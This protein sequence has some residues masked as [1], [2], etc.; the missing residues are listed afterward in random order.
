MTGAGQMI[1]HFGKYNVLRPLRAPLL[2]LMVMAACVSESGCSDFNVKHVRLGEAAGLATR[3]DIRVI[4]ERADPYPFAVQKHPTV[5][6]AE[7][8]PD[9]ALALN[10]AL[11]VE[12]H[13]KT[14]GVDAGAKGGY[15]T[16][17]AALALAGRTSAVVALRDG[18]FRACEGYANG[19]IGRDSYALILSHYGDLLVTLILGDSAGSNVGI[20]SSV[21][22]EKIDAPT[23]KS[24]AADA[25]TPAAKVGKTAQ[26]TPPAATSAAPAADSPKAAATA[27]V[28][29]SG[30]SA[31]PRGFTWLA[32]APAAA[33]KSVKPKPTPKSTTTAAKTAGFA[34]KDKDKTPSDAPPVF[35]T[36]STSAAEGIANAYFAGEGDRLVK[37]M[38][39][40]CTAEAERRHAA[41]VQ[42]P[43]QPKGAGDYFDRTCDV[44]LQ[45]LATIPNAAKPAKQ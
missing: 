13:A 29:L 40:V 41:G 4:T 10:R 34:A 6:C 25:T 42:F 23:V 12:A 16:N 9:V 28:Y 27:F 43:Q 21:T 15:Q 14:T 19:I 38:F 20:V 33:K 37:A 30:G 35:S 32:S 5:V 26:G 45:I 11:T 2:L 22:T 8:S 36:A 3:A 44:D 17:E 24:P 39:V 1:G 31:A 7:P 18:L